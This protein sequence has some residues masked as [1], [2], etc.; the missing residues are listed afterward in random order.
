M[1]QTVLLGDLVEKGWLTHGDGN[2][3][4]KYPS[5]SELLEHG[6]V[7]FIRREYKR[8]APH[9]EQARPPCGRK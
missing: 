8:F 4:S 2:Y 1:T 3:S 5:A 7:P 6:E 9:P